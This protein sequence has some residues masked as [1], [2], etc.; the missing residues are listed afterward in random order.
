MHDDPN[1][2]SWFRWRYA[3]YMLWYWVV[4]HHGR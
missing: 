3:E 4:S 2:V 1:D